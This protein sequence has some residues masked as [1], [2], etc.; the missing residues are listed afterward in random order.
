MEPLP[1]ELLTSTGL[2]QF[3][4]GVPQSNQWLLTAYLEWT[5]LRTMEVGL[6]KHCLRAFLT[7]RTTKERPKQS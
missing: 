6:A 5:Q 4:Q 1:K 2:T 3:H 7:T